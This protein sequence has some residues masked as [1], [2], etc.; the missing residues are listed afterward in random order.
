VYSAEERQILGLCD[1]LF[2][3]FEA[4]A[5][6]TKAITSSPTI[7][8]A[9]TKFDARTGRVIGR[10]VATVRGASPVDIVFKLMHFGSGERS[11][12]DVRKDL[13]ENVNDHHC[14]TFYEF[15]LAPFQNRTLLNA[16]VFEK[17]SDNPESYVWL[18]APVEKHERLTRQDEQHAVRAEGMR[19]CRLTSVEPN[20]TRLEYACCLDLKG[21]FPRWATNNVAVPKLMV[22]PI[23]AACRHDDPLDLREELLRT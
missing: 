17:V 9:E 10:A 22:R 6:R 18:G 3:S 1:A 15:E 4:A 11:A 16:L 14:V 23:R 5:G 13:L 7:E 2:I 19:C 8:V 21:R 20:V 12:V